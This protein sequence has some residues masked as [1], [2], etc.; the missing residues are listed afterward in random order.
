[1]ENN[2]LIKEISSPFFFLRGWLK[3]IGIA[4]I[5]SGVISALTL[6][7]IIFAWIPIWMGVTLF[8]ASNKI[9]MAYHTGDKFLLME[10]IS[11]LKTYFTIQGILLI[12]GLATS[13]ISLLFF[14]SIFAMFF[15]NIS[16]MY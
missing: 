8:S 11:K 5:I 15:D 9:E 10:A 6:I 12:L 3:F 2:E 13:L 7:G 1:M 16:S 4:L 14:G